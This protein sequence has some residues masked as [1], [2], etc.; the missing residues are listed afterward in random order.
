MIVYFEGEFVIKIGPLVATDYGQTCA[1]L[2]LQEEPVLDVQSLTESGLVLRSMAFWQHFMPCRFHVTPSIYVAREERMVLGFVS[3]H[4]VGKSKSCWRID[5]LVVHPE[6]RGRGIAQELLRYVF[7]QFGSQ[8]VS[9]FIAEIGPHNDAALSLFAA[10]GFCRSAKVTYFRLN[11]APAE[12]AAGQQ[13]DASAECAG[14]SGDFHIAMPGH[15]EA[16]YQLFQ[17]SLPTDLRQVL[18]LSADDFRVRDL[19]AFTTVEKAK[20]RLMRRRIWYWFA[21]DAERH[22]MTGAVRI[23]AQP[24]LGYRLDL[25]IHPGWRQVSHDILQH[26]INNLLTDVPR[27]PIWVRLFDFQSDAQQILV[28][29]GFERMGDFFLLSREHWQRAKYPKKRRAARLKSI[30]N[31]ALNLPLATERGTLL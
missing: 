14:V 12:G 28:D 2:G 4:P 22:T 31:P 6:H 20:N 27:Q 11:P 3:L 30:G 19:L 8:G 29:R 10:C 9:H 24:Q 23:T 21:Q 26:A 15:K 17:D 13:T 25:A 1:L 7:A 5:N 18:N 16:L